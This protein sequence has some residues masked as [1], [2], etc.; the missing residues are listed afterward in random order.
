MDCES[1]I[2]SP[3][4]TLENSLVMTISSTLQFIATPSFSLRSQSIHTLKSC[5]GFIEKK[6]ADISRG[7]GQ[8]KCISQTLLKVF[9]ADIYA[10]LVDILGHSMKQQINYV[11]ENTSD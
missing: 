8:R 5:S 7:T 2:L 6:L 9:E 3:R 4:A 1:Q 10:S 11:L